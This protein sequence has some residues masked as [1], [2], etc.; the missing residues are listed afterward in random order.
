[1]SIN[2]IANRCSYICMLVSFALLQSCCD[3]DSGDLKAIEQ[4]IESV[5]TYEKDTSV[6]MI[7]V[8]E[9]YNSNEAMIISKSVKGL[10]DTIKLKF[11]LNDKYYYEPKS[12]AEI[13]SLLYIRVINDT[14]LIQYRWLVD[15]NR[16]DGDVK[17]LAKGCACS[18]EEPNV[19]II[20]VEVEFDE[21]K[22]FNIIKGSKE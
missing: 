15:T 17:L 22:S 18:V 1:M 21:T 8:N 12:K 11:D 5:I 7:E 4:H 10:G 19:E 13:D 14:L 16:I 9:N 2:A 6:I 3:I 20:G